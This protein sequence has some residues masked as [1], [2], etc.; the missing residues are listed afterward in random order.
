MVQRGTSDFNFPIVLD[1]FDFDSDPTFHSDADQDPDPTPIFTHVGISYIFFN[2]FS[3]QCQFTLFNF[4]F[5]VID[6]IIFFGNT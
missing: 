3:Q 1:N 5:S 2:F 4:I 6:V